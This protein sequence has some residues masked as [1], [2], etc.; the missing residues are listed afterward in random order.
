MIKPCSIA[1]QSY[2][3]NLWQTIVWKVQ[4]YK[5]LIMSLIICTPVK[6]LGL[7]WCLLFCV[8][9][10]CWIQ[11]VRE[12][13]KTLVRE[14]S[15]IYRNSYVIFV[16]FIRYAFYTWGS[17]H[18]FY[19]L[20]APYIEAWCLLMLRFGTCLLYTSVVINSIRPRPNNPARNNGINT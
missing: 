4:R 10:Y 7:Y 6:S 19:F 20:H 11:Q 13:L 3:L 2:N 17:L 5:K 15:V 9:T 18:L 14:Q 16:L 1:K 12:R 8:A